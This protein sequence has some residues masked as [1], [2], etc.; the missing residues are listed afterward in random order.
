MKK[1]YKNKELGSSQITDG[2]E[3]MLS[4]Y[5]ERPQTRTFANN[6]DKDVLSVNVLSLFTLFLF[7]SRME[8]EKGYQT[9]F[10]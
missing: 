10:N 8:I 7:L 9:S 3:L 5:A 6:E 4:T 2:Q 1:L